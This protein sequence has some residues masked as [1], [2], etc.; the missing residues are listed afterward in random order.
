[1]SSSAPLKLPVEPD[2]PAV[3]LASS[4]CS[5]S[6]ARRRHRAGA[7]G[8][9]ARRGARARR[10]RDVPLVFVDN[11]RARR[12]YARYGFEAVG[13]YDFM[14]GNHAD[15]DI[16]MRKRSCERRGHPR[17]GLG[18]V[19]HGFLGRRGGV[20]RGDLRR[21]QRRLRQ[22]RRPRGDRRES[23]P[24]RRRGRPRR[25]LVT[26]HQVHSRR[27]VYADRAWPQDRARRPMRSSPTGRASL[28]GILTADCAPVL[29]ADRRRGSSL[30]PMP[31]GKARSAASSKRR[32]R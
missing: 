2:G 25:R 14:V 6:M 27:C 15:E 31:A 4:T 7:D 1:M 3:E 26:V 16:I 9:G 13:R 8:L 11:H 20:S 29:L 30:P 24:R 10:G 19:P 17:G 5:R 18:G 12:F 22:R 28:L 23:P 32:S 21:P